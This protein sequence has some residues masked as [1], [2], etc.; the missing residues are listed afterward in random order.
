MKL[1]SIEKR[2]FLKISFKGGSVIALSV[3]IAAAISFATQVVLA[4]TLEPKLF[5][6]ITFVMTVAMFLNPLANL[7]ADK[8]IIFQKDFSQ[9]SMDVTFTLELIAATLLTALVF[10]VA[11]S[12]MNLLGKSELTIYVQII[13][14][15]FLYNPLCR[16]RCLFERNLSFFHSKYPFV[17]SQFV[18]AVS[19]IAMAYF[20]FGL[21]SLVWWK[22]SGMLGETIILWSIA[23][24]RPRIALDPDIVAKLVR[25]SW[26]L[27]G[28]TFLVFFYYNVDYFIVGRFL[29]DGDVQLGYYSLG[30]QAAT[31]ILISRQLLYEVL[32][33][34]FSRLDDDDLRART[35]QRLTQ[36]VA[37]AFLVLTIL[38][39]FFG[40]DIIIQL[41]GVRWEPAVFPFQ[42][43]FIT[44]M[45]RAI[46]ANIVYYLRSRGQ[47]RPE[48]MMA[49]GFSVLL[50]PLA[51][52]ATIRYGINGTALAVLLI[53]VI[54]VVFAFERYIR[55]LTGKGVL[56][57]FLWPWVIS[58]F[59]L[60]LTLA[61]Q[62]HGVSFLVRL[63][64]CLVFLLITYFA[65][66]QTTFR[67]VL[68]TVRSLGE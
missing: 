15:A 54:V 45:M 50:P 8:F 47:N 43:I 21:W 25:F 56:H 18:A 13:A 41:Y 40:R 48:L 44:S 60:V 26:P 65:F 66:L 55:P 52:F 9:R 30:F 64:I 20:G 39:I 42:I 5:G 68:T 49:I 11:P 61:I 46:S 38:A 22:L 62:N 31:Y 4:R 35:F 63:M 10:F 58:G 27:V 37:G 3:V 67:D 33:P 2:D 32:F 6:Q 14:L 12:I 17:L 28:S 24:Y 23:P 7:H 36:A 29:E 57:F 53:Q 19:S 51:Y 59:A 16:P 1:A 34:I